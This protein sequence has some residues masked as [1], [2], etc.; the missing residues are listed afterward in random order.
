MEIRAQWFM[1]SV[2]VSI[3]ASREKS[4]GNHKFPPSWVRGRPRQP[5]SLAF[6]ATVVRI[7]GKLGEEMGISSL[8]LSQ[9]LSL[10]RSPFPGREIVRVRRG[11]A[12]EHCA[13]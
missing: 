2:N 7:W 9:G 1:A 4:H 12:E 10:S 6:R 5:K 13:A 3:G 11:W 8:S